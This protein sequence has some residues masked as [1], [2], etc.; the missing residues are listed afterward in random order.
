VKRTPVRLDSVLSSWWWPLAA[1]WLAF[2]CVAGSKWKRDSWKQGIARGI[3]AIAS[4][5]FG[6][7]LIFG[8]AWLSGPLTLGQR[9]TFLVPLLIVVFVLTGLAHTLLVGTSMSRQ[10]LNFAAWFGSSLASGALIWT[11]VAVLWWEP[12]QQPLYQ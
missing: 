12:E 10:Q 5:C 11:F 4:G 2:M 9:R 8:L 1:I 6:G 3:S 7:L